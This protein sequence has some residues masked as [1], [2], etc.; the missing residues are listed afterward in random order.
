[1]VAPPQKQPFVRQ[2]V[3]HGQPAV[4]TMTF[5]YTVEGNT[6]HCNVGGVCL[7]VFDGDKWVEIKTESDKLKENLLQNINDGIITTESIV[8]E[9][10]KREG[11]I[12][13]SVDVNMPFQ[14]DINGKTLEKRESGPARILVVI[15]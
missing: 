5:S 12:N 9:L 7:R 15:D 14:I 11:V 10:S 1:M 3:V 2:F 6:L 4:L 8:N 13:Y